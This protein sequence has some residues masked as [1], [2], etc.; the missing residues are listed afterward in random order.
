MTFYQF[1]RVTSSTNKTVKL[2]YFR[3]SVPTFRKSTSLSVF[4]VN[5]TLVSGHRD[6]QSHGQ[7]TTPARKHNTLMHP[8]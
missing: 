4:L 8:P 7:S 3:R 5:I 6:K 2:E 1:K